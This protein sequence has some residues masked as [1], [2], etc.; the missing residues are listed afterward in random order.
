ML[1]GGAREFA[2]QIE[3]GELIIAPS[4]GRS[5]QIS[6]GTWATTTGIP[7]HAARTPPVQSRIG[8][9][10]EDLARVVSLG[11]RVELGLKRGRPAEA[12]LR[13]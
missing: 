9:R 2:R 11:R 1:A 7:M 4:E 13:P 3:R 8:E 5:G 10:A 12:G 6:C